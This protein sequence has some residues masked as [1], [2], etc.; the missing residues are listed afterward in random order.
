MLVLIK[1]RKLGIRNYR[2]LSKI[3]KKYSS[4]INN[5]SLNFPNINDDFH[6]TNSNEGSNF[7][8]SVTDKNG[9]KCDNAFFFKKEKFN[10]IKNV[11][12]NNL[13][14]R[15]LLYY[16]GY[17]SKNKILDI[18]MWDTVMNALDTK[19]KDSID[20]IS[21][22]FNKN[23]KNILNSKC[24]GRE[25]NLKNPFFDIHD[26]MKIY[27]NICY[28]NSYFFLKTK[29]EKSLKGNEDTAS[30][31][32]PN[33]V[34]QNKQNNLDENSCELNKRI[35][36]VHTMNI[37]NIIE[38]NN[39]YQN[40][41]TLNNVNKIN[42]EFSPD[43]NKNTIF[44]S[45]KFIYMDDNANNTHKINMFY[46]SNGVKNMFNLLSIFFLQ[47]I[48]IINNHYLCRLFYGYNKSKFYNER[49]LNNLCFEIIKRIKKIRTYH[50]YLILVNSYYLNYIDNIFVKIILINTIN[51]LSQLPCE[52]ICQILHIVPLFIKSE[53]LLYKIN[54]IYSKKIA[55]FNQ[56]IH[57]VTLFKKM[58]QQKLI[59]QKNIFQTF[60]H[61][62]KFMLIKKKKT[63]SIPFKKKNPQDKNLS[64][65]TCSTNNDELINNVVNNFSAY[66][67]SNKKNK[68][69]IFNSDDA[70]NPEH[71][72]DSFLNAHSSNDN[73]TYNKN[74]DLGNGSSLI[75]S[76]EEK[77]EE[78]KYNNC[79]DT[80][81][82][83]Y[84]KNLNEDKENNNYNKDDLYFHLKIIDMH[85]RHDFKN[86]YCLFPI[87]YKN[88]LQK[89]R[90][91]SCNINKN[92]QGE[93]EIFI[94]KKYMKMLNYNFIT[95]V[96]GPYILHICDPFYKIYIDWK[97]SWKLYPVYKQASQKNFENDKINH[98]KKE[99]Y[100]EIL[101]CHDMFKN[102]KNENEKLQYINSIL[103]NT[104]FSKCLDI[105]N[106]KNDFTVPLQEQYIYI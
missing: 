7:A 94:L 106:N 35:K 15:E 99:G 65:D 81:L 38:E 50:L 86:I 76:K 68:H 5:N 75:T 82:I 95:F 55:T 34:F 84:N 59:S 79:T 28:I 96:Y 17:C 6:F 60:I 93:K 41:S 63:I 98:L 40:G 20:I 26:L 31:E 29:H 105:M 72:E 87:E 73:D 19:V 57:L 13:N 11:N 83:R 56:L 3:N 77:I 45:E 23:K 37:E 16:I 97:D 18:S 12:I 54:V 88:F 92:M 36:Q 8:N 74:K 4:F 22:D 24:Y 64:D 32:K 67:Y 102:C 78:I 42:Y 9:G 25:E 47:N 91:V 39:R 61:L 62:N 85:L 100:K 53:K 30:K 70:T 66:N 51:N 10:N 71:K 101:I 80:H 21:R 103:E 1:W 69:E 14:N 48:N 46:C 43:N 104:E 44:E 49:Y 58:L 52:A 2:L 89:V 90:N 27:Q 33:I